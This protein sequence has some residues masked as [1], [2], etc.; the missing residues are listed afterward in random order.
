M[1]RSPKS[2][3]VCTVTP[4]E[5]RVHEIFDGLPDDELRWL[6]ERGRAEEIPEGQ[7]YVHIGDEAQDMFFILEGR[8]HWRVEVGG[9]KVLFR[10]AGP[11]SVGG[12]LPY[13]RMTHYGGEALAVEPMRILRVPKEHFDELVTVSPRLGERL[14]AVMSTRVREATRTEQQQEKMMAL[15][16]LAAG[17]AHELN[18]PAAAIGRSVDALGERLRQLPDMVACLTR[19]DIAETAVRA[20]GNLCPLSRKGGTDSGTGS[21]SEL[22]RSDREDEVADWLDE[23]GVD[24]PWVRAETLVAAGLDVD[25]LAELTDGIDDAGVASLVTW[26]ETMLGAQALVREVRSAAGRVSELVAS[27]KQYSH[28]DR[29]AARQNVDVHRGLDDTLTMLGHRVRKQEVEIVRRYHDTLPPIPAHAGELNQVWTNLIDNALDA[30]GDAHPGGGGRLEL[31][32]RPLGAMV[33]ICVIDDGPGIPEDLVARIYEPFFTTKGVG[34]GTGLG[35]DIAHRIVGQH[36]GLLD[37][38][39][40]PGRTAFRVCLPIATSGSE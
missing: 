19:H 32:T 23:R 18:N 31:A 28:M 10:D 22:E 6:L 17:L 7:L 26:L 24:E 39:S 36:Q 16:K 11:G 14:V 1:A 9:Q 13:S 12:V 4:D 40:K 21:I 27:V 30:L 5:L 25:R 37:V 38:A 34:Q 35:L 3:A 15:G 33:E 8:S 29:S 20:A 2:P